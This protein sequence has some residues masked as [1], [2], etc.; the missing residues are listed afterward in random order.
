LHLEGSR[1]AIMPHRRPAPER[2]GAAAPASSWM[3]QSAQDEGKLGGGFFAHRSRTTKTSWPAWKMLRG[4][5]SA[6]AADRRRSGVVGARLLRVPGTK[7]CGS[8]S[9]VSPWR[10]QE[11]RKESGGANPSPVATSSRRCRV[12]EAAAKVEG[13]LE[14]A[15][16]QSEGKGEAG[17]R[18][19]D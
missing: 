16:L 8:T 11:A 6:T 13:L 10:T 9:S 18:A 7:T 17:A 2:G 1:G 12:T 15:C 14:R 5:G 3:R 4:R 19:R